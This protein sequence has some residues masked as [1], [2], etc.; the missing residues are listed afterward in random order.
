MRR[1]HLLKTVAF[2]TAVGATG[3]VGNGNENGDGG[4]N[5]ENG[6]GDGDTEDGDDGEQN[7]GEGVGRTD[8]GEE[9]GFEWEFE[10]T[11]LEAGNQVDNARIDPIEEQN[12][13][14][15]EG[16]THGSDLCK[17]AELESADYDPEEGTL[18]VSV[19]TREVEGAGDVCAGAI[20][21]IGYV[22]TFDFDDEMPNSASVSHDGRTAAGA[23]WSSESVT[24][25]PPGN[26]SE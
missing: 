26:E 5:D 21:E 2:A 7:S 18:E 17:T 12:R 14:V 16:T 6:D 4:G 9:E 19:T 24:E 13:V 25:S 10:I 23:A 8:T 11:S 22:A 3:C 15:V 1:R 20:R